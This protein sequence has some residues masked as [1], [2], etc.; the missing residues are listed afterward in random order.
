YKDLVHRWSASFEPLIAAGAPCQKAG[1]AIA[2]LEARL[3][4][5][6]FVLSGLPVPQLANEGGLGPAAYEVAGLRRVP[7]DFANQMDL[8]LVPGDFTWSWLFSHEADAWVS[9]HLYERTGDRE[10]G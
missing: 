5:E 1:R 10:P 6:V 7:R 9:E 2:S 8:T 4:A 3:P